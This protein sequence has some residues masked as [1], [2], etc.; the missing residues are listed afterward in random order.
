MKKITF[1]LKGVQPL[2]LNNPQAVNPLNAYAKKLKPLTSK[3]TKTDAD[4]EDIYRIKFESC[5]YQNSEGQYIIPGT[6]FEQSL[7]SAAKETKQGKMFERS[8]NI[9]S[10]SILHF[11]DEDKSIEELYNAGIYV[12]IRCVGI[13]DSKI[14]TCRAIVH[15]WS[16]E[17]EVLYDEN[18]IN[19]KDIISAM[20]IAGERYG[21]GTYRQKY[22]RFEVISHK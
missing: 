10:D 18:Q 8:L 4:H 3:R 13:K 7:I 9:F 20:K 17:V 19:A 14:T 11:K 12:D 21:V 15:D 16:C 22:G 1:K 6:H 2:M 5:W